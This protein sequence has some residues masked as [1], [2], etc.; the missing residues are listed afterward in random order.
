MKRR[1]A[2]RTRDGWLRGRRRAERRCDSRWQPWWS[3]GLIPPNVPRWI[4]SSLFLSDFLLPPSL[5]P[6]IRLSF[7]PLCSICFS[8]QI[9]IS[10]PFFSSLCLSF[11]IFHP[12]HLW[13]LI[14]LMAL[15]GF[16]SCH[17]TCHWSKGIPSDFS[18][19]VSDLFTAMTWTLCLLQINLRAPGSFTSSE[20][21]CTFCK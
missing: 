7:L 8:F 1:L 15:A 3:V 9:H 20:G 11:M 5:N 4:V 10:L 18:Y 19:S 12:F 14:H 6:S 13:H 17:K 2:Q 16:C 21:F